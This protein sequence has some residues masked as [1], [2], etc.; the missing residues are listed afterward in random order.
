ME[1]G[2]TPD[3]YFHVGM[4]KAASTFLQYNVFPRFRNIYYIQRTKYRRSTRIISRGRYKRYLVSGELDN[5]LF[6]SYI[7]EFSSFYP[8]AKTIIILRNHDSWIASQ[9]RRYI[10]NGNPWKFHEFIDLENDHGYWKQK[11]LFYFPLIRLLEQYFRYRPYVLF[12]DDLRNNPEEFI[13]KIASYV[14]ASYD[15]TQI[16]LS[17][18][19]SSYNEK[20]LKAILHL[21]RRINI[22]R[23]RKG[24][25]KTLRVLKGLI[26]NFIRY[27][28]LYLALLLPDSFFGAEVLIPPESLENIKKHYADDWKQCVTYAMNNNPR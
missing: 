6:E 8:E 5:R 24:T 16:D 23:K 9:Y 12:Y 28:T 10:K 19:H 1:K 13:R 27:T 7:K 15:I 4:G 2:A 18:R 21:S 11:D 3:I 22:R 25:N 17:R 26:P 14:G 20:Q